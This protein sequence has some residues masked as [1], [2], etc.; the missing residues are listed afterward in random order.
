MRGVLFWAAVAVVA[1]VL[2]LFAASNRGSVELGLWPVPFVVAVPVYL[3]VFATLV[4]GFVV[5]WLATWFGRQRLRLE[6]RRRRRRI[7]A[8][9][10]ELAA[11]QARLGQAGASSPAEVAARR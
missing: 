1:I 8:L 10:K 4:V 7:E 5:G 11:T 3:L 6:S 9:E 2:I